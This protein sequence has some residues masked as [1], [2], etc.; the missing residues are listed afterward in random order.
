MSEEDRKNREFFP[1][2]SLRLLINVAF[3]YYLS[4]ANRFLHVVVPKGEAKCGLFASSHPC[5]C[6]YSMLTLAAA[7]LVPTNTRDL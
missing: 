5:I 4:H 2:Y 1:K 7:G 3:S 6:I